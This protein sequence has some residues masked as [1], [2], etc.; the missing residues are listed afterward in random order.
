MT[1]TIVVKDI[2]IIDSFMYDWISLVCYYVPT[3]S[4]F[5][6]ASFNTNITRI[7]YATMI[8]TLFIPCNILALSPFIK[9]P[10]SSIHLRVDNL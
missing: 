2:I 6:M 1:K 5:S 10:M 4:S 3:I 9:T 7:K 8:G